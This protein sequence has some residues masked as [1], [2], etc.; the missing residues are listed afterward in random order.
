MQ[1]DIEQA[2]ACLLDYRSRV[3]GWRRGAMS[4]AD[5]R[6][7]VARLL[8]AGF[9]FG[10]DVEADVQ[11]LGHQADFA[12]H[13][14][15]ER[16]GVVL[17][18]A[19]GTGTG[20]SPPPEAFVL[21]DGAGCR[22]TWLT[23]GTTVVVFHVDPD[24]VARQ[25]LTMDLSSDSEADL[26]R[27]WELLNQPGVATGRLETYRQQQLRPGPAEIHQ[28]LQAPAVLQALRQT[29][30]GTFP[31]PGSDE[32]LIAQVMALT[33]GQDDRPDAPRPPVRD[34]AAGAGPAAGDAVATLSEPPALAAPQPDGEAPVMAA[35]EAPALVEDPAPPPAGQ[36]APRRPPRPAP[37]A[38][39]LLTA[40][41][42]QRQTHERLRQNLQDLKD[43]R[44]RLQ[45]VLTE[46]QRDEPERLERRLA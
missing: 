19:M 9:G 15:G 7:R 31:N 23:D 10:W 34:V 12:L 22:W 13:V 30:A 21:A 39:T 42:K 24:L 25:V 37:V 44:A 5:T 33:D 28:A 3:G 46:M 29:L 32:E 38:D 8:D 17:V 2:W 35:P 41:E 18:R 40:M 4:L 11:T 36:P 26:R 16:W 45:D 27:H 1:T 20:D 14:A 6:L 43:N